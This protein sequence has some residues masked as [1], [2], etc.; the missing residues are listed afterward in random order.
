MSYLDNTNFGTTLE[1]VFNKFCYTSGFCKL[2]ETDED[3]SII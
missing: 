3:K 1:H 2:D